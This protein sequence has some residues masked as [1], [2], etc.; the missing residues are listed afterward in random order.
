M[1]FADQFYKI[2]GKFRITVEDVVSHKTWI[3]YEDDNTIVLI[4]KRNVTRMIGNDNVT[5]RVLTKMK[6]GDGGHVSDPLDPNFGQATATNENIEDLTNTIITKNISSVTFTDSLVNQTSSALFEA[7]ID[8]TEGNGAG[9][10]QIY[11][12]AGLFTLNETYVSGT[13]KNSGLFAVKHFPILTKT[14]ELRF[15]FNWTITI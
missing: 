11:S 9:G 12:E 10:T 6:F 5:Q 4:A 8:T 13:I 1:K 15:V 7:I 14:A 2:R 3:H